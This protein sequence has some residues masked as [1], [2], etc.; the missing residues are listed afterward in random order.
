MGVQ[1]N[2]RLEARDM[3][4]Y[5]DNAATTKPYPSVVRAVSEA[6]EHTWGNPSSSHAKGMEAKR[7]LEASRA[8][9]AEA[10]GVL[11]EEIFFTSGGTESNN[12]AIT[13]AALAY[14]REHGVGTVITSE[15]EHPS[16]TKTI[17]GL[18]RSGWSVEYLAASGGNLDVSGLKHVLRERK[19]VALISVMSVQ[20]ELG[21]VFPVERI[22]ALREKCN[23]A[24]LVHTDAAQAFGKIECVASRLGVDM[25]SLSAH[26]IGGP[27]GI[28]ALYVKRG[29]P[30]FTTAFGGGQEQ[31]LRSGTQAVPLIAG[32]AEAVRIAMQGRAMALRNCSRL[33]QM[34]VSELRAAYPSLVLNSRSD[35]SPFIVSVSLPGTNNKK[36]MEALSDR[37]IYIST[38][39]ACSSN[40][41]TV[42]PG[43]WREKH[44]LALQL[45]GIPKGLTRSTYRISFSSISTQRDVQRFLKAFKEV[46]AAS[47]RN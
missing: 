23:P 26:K 41:A 7:L 2:T 19:D 37:G 38:A 39:M 12:L 46:V 44:P 6:L 1:N 35:G 47:N 32:F 11:P 22:S 4:T 9:V 5:L 14:E 18:K 34:L 40:H 17:R 3:L 36:V 27:K 21:Y 31:G 16:V 25:M 29:T 8:T 30:L 24:A 43:T 28:G 13:G 10:L 45:A 42:A 33:S 15:L 20:S